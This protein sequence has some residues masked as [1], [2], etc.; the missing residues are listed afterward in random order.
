MSNPY[1]R[2]NPLAKGDPSPEGIYRAVGL[3]LTTW[4]R[5]EASQADLFG[6]IVR[7]RMGASQQAYG[8]IVPAQTKRDMLVT[9]A[10]WTFR[11]SPVVRDEVKR[12]AELTLSFSWRRNDIAHGVAT[13]L[14]LN[15]T[16]LGY[17]LAPSIHASRKIDLFGL[18]NRKGM[19]GLSATYDYLYTAAQIEGIAAQF[20]VHIDY[21]DKFR[22]EI[23]DM[24]AQP[25][26]INNEM[27]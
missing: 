16:D 14:G 15:E 10:E 17:Y 1:D 11:N 2:P 19:A 24:R 23:H 13:R 27:K 4:E 20:G 6:E 5:L 26:Y 22:C 12:V 8:I 25:T 21:V 9:V 7:A 18:V 3:A